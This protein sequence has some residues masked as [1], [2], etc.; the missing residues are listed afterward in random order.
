LQPEYQRDPN[1]LAMLYVRSNNGKLVPLSA[2]ANITQTVAL[3]TVN[4]LAQLPSA[5]ISFDTLPEVSLSQA[6]AAIQKLAEEILPSTIT[7]NFQGSAQVFNQSFG[8][9]GWL[10]LISIVVIYLIL[11]ILYED[12]IHPITILYGL[13]SAGFGALL[14]LYIFQ[15]ELNLYSFIGMILLVGIVKK[16]GIMLVDFTI[17]SQ[18]QDGKSPTMAIYQA[19]LVRFCY[20]N[21]IQMIN[22]ICKQLIKSQLKKHGFGQYLNLQRNFLPL[23]YRFLQVKSP[24]VC[25]VHCTGMDQQD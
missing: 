16:N 12:F 11:G 24:M 2:I 7:T 4:H 18:R 9:L 1:A 8:N 19:C 10:L 6:T 15:V 22:Y 25:G 23:N 20:I 13:P 3:L 21:I 14:T 17:E 5:T